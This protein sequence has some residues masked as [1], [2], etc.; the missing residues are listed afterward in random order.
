MY[1]LLG[2][3]KKHTFQI[4]ACTMVISAHYKQSGILMA[5]K[6]FSSQHLIFNQF[7]WKNFRSLFV[8]HGKINVIYKSTPE[9]YPIQGSIHSAEMLKIK[10][11]KTLRLKTFL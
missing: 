3:K 4:E 8:D 2:K 6:L 5:L 11:W 9:L 7:L 1:F 10:M